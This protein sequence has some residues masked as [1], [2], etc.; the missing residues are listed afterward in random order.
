MESVQCAITAS[1]TVADVLMSNDCD[2][3]RLF[4]AKHGSRE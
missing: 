1:G 4:G 2:L 3:V